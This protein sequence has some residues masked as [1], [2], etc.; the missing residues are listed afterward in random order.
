[1]RM[2]F[3]KLEWMKTFA[4]LIRAFELLGA[5]GR[6]TGDPYTHSG[7]LQLKV[8]E[9]G[10]CA[11]YEK[12]LQRVWPIS[13]ENRKAK[14]AEFGKKRGLRLAYY[15]QGHCAIFL[16]SGSPGQIAERANAR[17]LIAPLVRCRLSRN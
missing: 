15:K 4:E 1:M 3:E 7:Q 10:H 6:R 12:E 2:D 14:I 8:S 17:G 11:V 9:L 13:E 5:S 16:D